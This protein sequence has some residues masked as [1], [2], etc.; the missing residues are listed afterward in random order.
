MRSGVDLGSRDLL[1]LRYVERPVQSALMGRIERL[2][3][4]HVTTL[5]VVAF[6]QAFRVLQFPDGVVL[7]LFGLGHPTTLCMAV[8]AMPAMLETGVVR[9][10]HR[11]LGVTRMPGSY[12]FRHRAAASMM[13]MPAVLEAR[14]MWMNL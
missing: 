9:H 7:H 4:P 14:I 13:T 1:P 10:D 12:Q 2:L 8:M 11:L 5:G 3:H 6:L